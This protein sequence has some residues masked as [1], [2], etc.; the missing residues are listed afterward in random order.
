MQAIGDAAMNGARWVVALDDD[1]WKRL[2]A[3]EAKAMGDW[4]KICAALAHYEEHRE[5]RAAVP[6]RAGGDRRRL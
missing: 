3:R 5:W 1:L 6:G 4:A 2:M